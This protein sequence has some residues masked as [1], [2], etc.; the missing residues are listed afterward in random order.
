MLR[1]EIVTPQATL[2]EC[3]AQQVQV[4][5][6]KAPFAMLTRHQA[7]ISSLTE[8]NVIIFKS[9]GEKITV[10]LEGTSIVEQHENKITIL[11]TRA[12]IL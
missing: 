9:N 2:L 7:I 11:A 10:K 6:T 5:G 8:D 3:E 12:K 4:P 1:V